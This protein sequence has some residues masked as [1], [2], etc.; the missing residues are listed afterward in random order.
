MNPVLITS[1][2]LFAS[3]AGAATA[4]VENTETSIT[5]HR[6][7]ESPFFIIRTILSF[8]LK[9]LNPIIYNYKNNID[10]R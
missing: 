10:K 1:T 8:L 5:R 2:T 7:S 9:G 4:I 6:I 3:T